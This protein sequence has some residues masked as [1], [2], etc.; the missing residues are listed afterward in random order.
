VNFV[1][2]TLV[3]LADPGTRAAV[4]D[5]TGLEQVVGAAYDVDAMGVGGPFQPV[6]EELRLGVAAPQLGALEGT[7]R[8][9]GSV[10]HSEAR[11]N[12]SG[13]GSGSPLRIDAFWRGAIVARFASA[14]EPITSAGTKWPDTGS[15]DAEIA[16]ASGGNLPADRAVLEQE[17]RTRFLDRIRKAL[18]QPDA[19]SDEVFDEWLRSVGAGSVNELFEHFEGSVE[20]GAVK[21]TFAPPAAVADTPRPLPIAAAVVVRDAAGFSLAQLLADSKAIIERLQP[22]GLERSDDR[23]LRL[24]RRL[25]VVWV[26]PEGVFDDTDWPG[27]DEA[28]LTA[29]QRRTRR[30]VAAGT[31]LAAEGIGLVTTPPH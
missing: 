2:F 11:F 12:L 16:A 8:P 28:N 3:R 19:F 24:R 27:G 29:D 5:Q 30:R 31:W 22:L 25:I 7:W 21:V 10:D 6:F 13:L 15:I 9:V 1:D 26:V 18:D 4:F 14:G 17:R 23:S 20:L